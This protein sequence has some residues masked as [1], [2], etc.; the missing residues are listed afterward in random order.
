MRYIYSEIHIDFPGKLV[1]SSLVLQSGERALHMPV[2][3][4]VSIALNH[5]NVE[6]GIH[7]GETPSLAGLPW[8]CK[9]PNPLLNLGSQLHNLTLVLTFPEI[10]DESFDASRVLL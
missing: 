3:Q 5:H 8:Q 9:R 6:I 1:S 4:Q 10:F 7:I 2:K